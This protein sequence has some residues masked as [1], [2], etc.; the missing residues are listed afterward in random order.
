MKTP[1]SSPE[2]LHLGHFAQDPYPSSES[3]SNSFLSAPVFSTN[4]S[5]PCSTCGKPGHKS[6][7]CPPTHL[8]CTACG[9]SN[10]D[11]SNC[12][13]EPCAFCLEWGHFS[14]VCPN[15]WKCENCN[16][17]THITNECPQ[18]CA[19]CGGGHCRTECPVMTSFLGR[20]I[21]QTHD[22]QFSPTNSNIP[23]KGKPSAAP[24]IY[25]S[26]LLA[27]VSPIPAVHTPQPETLRAGLSQESCEFC[28]QTGH[29]LTT[30]PDLTPAAES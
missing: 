20:H 28:H 11:T 23:V 5:A 10:H 26:Q 22:T 27:W 4:R 6:Y 15:A 13:G 1:L 12:K 3:N 8:H 16:L 30:C 25:E 24:G 14:H 29:T 21:R 2:I 17:T 9:S 19:V 18:P 7:Q